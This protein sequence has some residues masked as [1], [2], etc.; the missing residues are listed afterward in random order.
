MPILDEAAAELLAS[1]VTVAGRRLR[2]ALVSPRG[3][4]R[5][6]IDLARWLDTRALSNMTLPAL[7]G[8]QPDD[9][10]AAFLHE[11]AIQAILHELLAARLT[12]APEAEA[13]RLSE[14]FTAS[15]NG[16]LSEEDSA[17]L[18]S[19]FNEQI[20]GL[21][22]RLRSADPELLHRIRQEAYLARVVAAIDRH[23]AVS[24]SRPDPLGDRDFIVRY[25]RHA[26][27]YHGRLQPPDFE[28]RRLVPIDDLYVSP[29]ISHLVD[30]DPGMPLPQ[31]DIWQLDDELDRAVLLGDPGGGKTTASNVLMHRHA[32]DA[33][34][35][36][37]FLV[38]VREFATAD[39][40]QRSVL[41]HLEHKLE[42][43][44]QAAPPTGL[45]ESLLFGGSAL[46]IFDGLDEL[47]DTSARSEVTA[48]IER[49]CAEYPLTRVLVTSRVVGYDQARLDD[50]QF[51]CYQISGFDTDQI[52][53]Y[54]RKWFAC[55]D[56]IDPGEA[57]SFLEES[58]GADDLRS[59]PLM[60]ALMCILY[61]GEGSIPRS[62]PEV[63]E[64]CATLLFHKW[65]AARKIHANLR[66]RNLIEPALRYLAH[67][68][69]TRAEAQPAVTEQELVSQTTRYFLSRG[70]EQHADAEV[71]A[72]EFVEFCRGRLWVFTEAGTTG[73]GEP[74]YAFTHRTFLEYFTAAYLASIHD[75][76][77]QL[78]RKLAGRVAKSE[79]DTVAQLAIQIK[80]HASERG[81][82][83]I[84]QTLLADRRHHT[85]KASGNILGFLGRC[86][87]FA[88]LAPAT[89]RNLAA[90]TFAH[91]VIDT[92]DDQ[93]VAP[94]GWLMVS[95][96][97]D[98]RD[99]VAS[100]LEA[101]V[102][103]LVESS[104]GQDHILGLRLALQL[105]NAPFAIQRGDEAWHKW[106]V[107]S[108]Y[109]RQLMLAAKSADDIAV[110]MC[111]NREKAGPI[112]A[113]RSDLPHFL[114]KAPSTGF[115]NI[116][117]ISLASHILRDLPYEM[118]TNNP[119]L[120][121]VD[122][123][124][125]ADSLP[126]HISTDNS[127]RVF[128]DNPDRPISS[129]IGDGRADPNIYLSAAY[130]VCVLAEFSEGTPHLTPAH[131]GALAKLHPYLMHRWEI[132][133]QDLT[134]KYSEVG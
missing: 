4:K 65:D 108:R 106:D 104:D 55:Q 78:A 60:L 110:V 85:A 33:G 1:V 118:S 115:L 116:S 117:W 16:F 111:F 45:V 130:I 12:D 28:R 66:A 81:A 52:I 112:L 113:R 79:W 93:L 71:A 50:R 83:R 105:Y 35:H 70:F 17:T 92:T 9:Q 41:H 36:L 51:E 103:A 127:D 80:D 120:G 101:R 98:L 25:R 57:D 6:D 67:W 19:F 43:F 5:A 46:V 82:D 32:A 15:G 54:V 126:P 68:L 74:L 76:P 89:T 84:F 30:V 18:F 47:L 87:A 124:L 69:F 42:T 56:G 11:N 27:E 3:R 75:S 37:P 132:A 109:E 39:P 90:R 61:R 129:A 38:I 125:K 99:H 21:V 91:A 114:F 73:R 13:D 97:G 62:R 119:A 102:A 95:V 134:R 23:N 53:D 20:C 96:Q 72:Q 7:S 31:T 77:E 24:A 22:G 44:Y 64:K 131:L 86:T 88:E 34:R 14:L 58:A 121:Y 29:A 10:V 94:L 123:M 26:A 133:D 48:I 100:E 128:W 122:R 40:P 63:Y 8:G 107:S 49:F 2:L 59:N